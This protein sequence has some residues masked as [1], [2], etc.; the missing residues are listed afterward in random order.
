MIKEEGSVQ[1]QKAQAPNSNETREVSSTGDYQ[2]LKCIC[3]SPFGVIKAAEKHFSE[4]VTFKSKFGALVNILMEVAKTVRNRNEYEII[5]FLVHIQKIYIHQRFKTKHNTPSQPKEDQK[6]N[7]QLGLVK[8]LSKDL[9]SEDHE[10]GFN[11]NCEMCNRQFSEVSQT[12]TLSC[13][14]CYCINCMKNL[15]FRYLL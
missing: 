11:I 5:K 7:L 14:H 1:I 8:S 10:P 3:G 9:D 13:T 12:I 4:C 6:Q 2:K 15:I